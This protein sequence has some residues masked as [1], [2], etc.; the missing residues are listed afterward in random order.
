MYNP[1]AVFTEVCDLDYTVGTL[2][3]LKDR[4]ITVILLEEEDG[5]FIV[6]NVIK[7]AE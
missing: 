2:R 6:V 7:E 4:G 5:Q 1:L 3:V